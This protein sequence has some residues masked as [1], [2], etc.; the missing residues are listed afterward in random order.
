MH[1]GHIKSPNSGG[2][3]RFAKMDKSTLQEKLN[4]PPTLL[5]F[6]HVTVMRGAPNQNIEA[7]RVFTESVGDVNHVF[8]KQ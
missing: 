7:N 5:F 3:E 8:I 6:Y 1:R 4:D 2:I